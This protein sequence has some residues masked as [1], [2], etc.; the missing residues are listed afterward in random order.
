MILAGKVSEEGRTVGLAI[1]VCIC[2]L[3]CYRK[4]IDCRALYQIML[5]IERPS[6][7]LPC[8]P[9]HVRQK[10]LMISAQRHSTPT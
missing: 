3:V 10:V 8:R 9:C 2:I 4:T 1:D 7:P 6:S 5:V